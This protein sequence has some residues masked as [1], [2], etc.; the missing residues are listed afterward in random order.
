MS[1]STATFLFCSSLLFIA[2]VSLFSFFKPAVCISATCLLPFS[3]SDILFSPKE[4]PATSANII[5]LTNILYFIIFSLI[6]KIACHL[7]CSL[8]ISTVKDRSFL[9]YIKKC[10]I[11]MNPCST[12]LS[13]VL[14]INFM[15]FNKAR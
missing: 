5:A 6:N 10:R 11:I 4:G 14:F 3:T 2:A 1:F 13:F 7:L 9:L 12:F 15:F 8:F